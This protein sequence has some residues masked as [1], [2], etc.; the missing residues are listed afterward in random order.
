MNFRNSKSVQKI[1]TVGTASA[2][3]SVSALASAAPSLAMPTDY[4]DC[5]S[6]SISV[7]RGQADVGAGVFRVPL[8]FTNIGSRECVI[9]GSP[10]IQPVAAGAGIHP[11]GPAAEPRGNATHTRIV[12]QP[13]QSATTTLTDLNGAKTEQVANVDA[14]RVTL[15]SGSKPINVPYDGLGATDGVWLEIDALHTS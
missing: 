1:L 2:A 8:T 9:T 12:L 4:Q 6:K 13:G 3:V 14:L 10:T 7:A 15:P 5:T 11:V